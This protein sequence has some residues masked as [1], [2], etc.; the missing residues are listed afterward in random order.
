MTLDLARLREVA[1]ETEYP[2]Y[3][4]D[5]DGNVWSTSNWRGYGI[6]K[7]SLHPN[8]HGYLSVKVKTLDGRT[9]KALVHKMVCL[10]FHGARPTEN[11]QVR[12]LDGRRTN[13]NS[14]N[15]CWGT[16]QENAIDRKKHGTEKAA[17]NG[18]RSAAK[19]FGRR[20]AY[21]FRGH[22]KEGRMDC[23]ECRKFR[24]RQKMLLA[25]EESI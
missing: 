8:S 20:K 3:F 18:K 21:C 17:E 25:K 19:L 2:G 13:N 12:H 9:K 24:Y 1:E 22:H 15:L 10:A 6:I 4:V 7:L 5:R 16:A 14:Q 11:H 23:N